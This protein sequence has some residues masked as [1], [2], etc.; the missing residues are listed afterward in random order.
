MDEIIRDYRMYEIIF[1]NMVKLV[2]TLM[3]IL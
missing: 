1:S 2:D 3:F